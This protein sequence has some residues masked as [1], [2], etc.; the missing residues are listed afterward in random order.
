MY[1]HFVTKQYY[2]TIGLEIHAELNTASKMFC[3]CKNDPD[4]TRPN[5][6][7]CPICMGHPGTLPTANKKAIESVIKVGLAVDGTI[8]DFTEFDRK[9]YFYPDIPKGYQI[10]QYKFPIVSG[11]TLNNIALTRIHIEEDTG[12]SKHDRGDFTLVDFNRAGVP[13]MEL[14]TEPVIHSAK[15]AGD[16]A[17]ELQ[18]LLRYL[19]VSEANMEKGEMRVEANIS[20]SDDPKQFGTKVEVKNLNSFRSVERA[21]AFE[22]NRMEQ[23]YEAGKQDEIVQ[24]TRGWDENK[25]VTFSQRSKESAHDYR[26]FPDPDLPKMKLHSVFDIERMKKELP[27]LPWQVRERLKERIKNSEL[28]EI[29]VQDSARRTLLMSMPVAS[30][31][32]AANYIVSIL[33]SANLGATTPANF[34][35]VIDMIAAGMLSST[36]GKELIGILIKEGG[37]P[38]VTAKNRGMLQL[39][40]AASLTP[41]INEVISE[42]EKIVADYKGGKEA[43]LQSLIGQV[44]KKTKGA[45]NP[46]VTLKILKEML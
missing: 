35:R 18:L 20:L 34:G 3:A 25:Q 46:E 12:L 45:A 8:A 2:P 19:G 10:S 36:A 17:R 28:I 38:D 6:N 31:E 39:S 16:F 26:Y 43:A 4:E 40:D 27:Q 21:I 7:I 41:T 24:E 32:L 11:G 1:N 29:F 14:V 44:M 23:L 13:L 42:N 5:A 22:L 9:N 37:D 33:D 30:S 15:E